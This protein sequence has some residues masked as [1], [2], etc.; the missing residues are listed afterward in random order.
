MV[1]YAKAKAVDHGLAASGCRGQTLNTLGNHKTSHTIW[2]L[3][4]STKN[5]VNKANKAK[6]T[7][8][9]GNKHTNKKTNNHS[10]NE[11]HRQPQDVAHNLAP[12]LFAKQTKGTKQKANKNA[13][14]K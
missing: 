2:P 13:N 9:Q 11:Y 5:K 14:K 4:S 6:Q 3:P 7:N 12:A 10:Y 8:K 1:W